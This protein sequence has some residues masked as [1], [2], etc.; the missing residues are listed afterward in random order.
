MLRLSVLV[1]GLAAGAFLTLPS[2]ANIITNGSFESYGTTS[3]TNTNASGTV[4]GYKLSLGSTDSG[5]RTSTTALPGWTVSRTGDD[6]AWFV[7]QNYGQIGTIPDGN[8]ALALEKG[9]PVSQNFMAEVGKT[10]TVSY[11]VKSCYTNGDGSWGHLT[12]S[13]AVAAST[14]NLISYTQ[15]APVGSGSSSLA[16]TT[17]PTGAWTTY[18]YVFT[19][20][21]NTTA[22]LNFA[23]ADTDDSGVFLDNVVVTAVPEPGALALAAGLVIMVLGRR[24]S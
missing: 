10:Y 21:A 15:T 19:V 22:T 24:R 14:L 7:N 20:G 12:S 4:I 18:T 5:L 23:S 13:I 8:W 1:A 3:Y 11:Y 6:F 16:Q 9:E 17:T 2:S